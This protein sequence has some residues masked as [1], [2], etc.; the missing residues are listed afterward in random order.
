MLLLLLLPRA[1]DKRCSA[2]LQREIKLEKC[3][4]SFQTRNKQHCVSVEDEEASKQATN[5]TAKI[6][7]SGKFGSSSTLKRQSS[8]TDRK[9]ANVQECCCFSFILH[10]HSNGT[11]PDSE[12]KKS[13]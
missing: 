10:M 7:V 3:F 12:N 11:T 5:E 1:T 13:H 4:C 9:R 2:A 8:I 6:E